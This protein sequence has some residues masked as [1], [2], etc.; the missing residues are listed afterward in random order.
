MEVIME[1]SKVHD[2]SI[3]HLFGEV[4]LMEMDHIE[5]VLES[6]RQSKLNKVLIDLTSVDHIHYVVIKRLIDNAVHFRDESGD[7]KLVSTNADM[8]EILRF[9]G[10]DQF[11][12]D[13][14][15][16]SEAILSFLKYGEVQERVY[17]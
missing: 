4:S 1:I 16:I 17:Q 10:A 6:F 5:R 3:L 14:A 12:E 8:K 7:I 9:A 11:L 15:T 13:Y 2:I